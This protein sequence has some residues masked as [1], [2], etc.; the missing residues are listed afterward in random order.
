MPPV[1]RIILC[2]MTGLVTY[3]LTTV[4]AVV[5][6]LL[7]IREVYCNKGQVLPTKDTRKKYRHCITVIIY[8]IHS[9]LVCNGVIT[10]YA[11]LFCNSAIVLPR[12]QA[13][14]VILGPSHPSYII[15]YYNHMT[16]LCS[17]IL[18]PYNRGTI[19]PKLTRIHNCTRI[20]TAHASFYD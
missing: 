8:V 16:N 10:T 19:N 6:A 12:C 20:L 5:S 9:Q 4:Y 3:L 17:A 1:I 15:L 18:T 11:I 2:Q 14:N 7:R 13:F